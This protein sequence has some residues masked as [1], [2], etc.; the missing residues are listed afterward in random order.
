M[1]ESSTRAA[2]P[3]RVVDLVA[4]LMG[5]PSTTST[6]PPAQYLVG[7][8]GLLPTVAMLMATLNLFL[9]SSASQPEARDWAA[10]WT[11]WV[12]L[13]S[14]CTSGDSKAFMSVL[15]EVSLWTPLLTP[16]CPRWACWRRYW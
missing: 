15:A 12:E 14:E 3:R 13:K 7:L 16:S 11:V 6:A 4:V 10:Q 1:E 2:R 8:Y 5:R 9:L